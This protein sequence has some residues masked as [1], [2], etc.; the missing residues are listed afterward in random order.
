MRGEWKKPVAA[1]AAVWL[2][3]GFAGA[4]T[5]HVPGDWPTIQ[6]SVDAADDGDTVLVQPGTY[7]DSMT[8]VWWKSIVI[9]GTDPND[10]EVIAATVADGGHRYAGS[11]FY[12]GA[13]DSLMV[14]EGLT[15]THRG[16]GE[17]RGLSCS[18]SAATVRRC[19]ITENRVNWSDGG[20]VYVFGG[21]PVIEDCVIS[22]NQVTR[23]DGGGIY[24]SARGGRLERCL[25]LNNAVQDGDGGGLSL[26]SQITVRGCTIVGNTAVNGGGGGLLIWG[27][28]DAQLID[29][30]ITGNS[31]KGE[32]GYW[33]WIGRGGGVIVF[34][35]SRVLRGC[36]I[37]NNR[38]DRS[39]GGVLHV[40]G[41]LLLEDSKVRGNFAVRGGGGIEIRRYADPHLRRVEIRDNLVQ[42]EDAQGA[43]LNIRLAPPDHESARLE[44]C[45][46]TGNEARG[47]WASGGAITA[48]VWS[49]LELKGCVISGN[50]ATGD[51]TA[52][53][54]AFHGEAMDRASFVNCIISGNRATGGDTATGGAIFGDDMELATFENCTITGNAA[55]SGTTNA[56]GGIQATRAAVD[57]TN[58]IVWGNT[59]ADNVPKALDSLKMGFVPVSRLDSRQPSTHFRVRGK[60]LRVD[61]LTP[62][63]EVCRASVRVPATLSGP[64]PLPE[65][66][67]DHARLGLW[68]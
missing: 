40:G 55:T 10:P 44:Q 3:A 34:G 26:L 48:H 49:N 58:C 12:L 5:I 42:G 38:A 46:I 63:G 22:D 62:G 43:G 45:R 28:D 11:V 13:N 21:E 61:L 2:S 17:G 68:F 31:A 8:N 6:G 36:E 30:V 57:L 25:I 35:A 4:T 16:M 1:L 39:G 19:W 33:E 15:L 65:P 60:Q 32:D 53:G 66:R 7:Q 59:G 41:E 23:G 9:R 29:C 64:W 14:L 27:P 20:G 51:D 24:W 54:G 52:A 47:R 56:Y 37:S 50:S 67:P 18:G